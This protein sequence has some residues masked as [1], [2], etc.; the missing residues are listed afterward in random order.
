LTDFECMIFEFYPDSKLDYIGKFAA[1]LGI[2]YSDNFLQIPSP[3]GEGFIKEVH[4]ESD[5]KI[6]IHKYQLKQGLTIRRLV[7]NKPHN[8]LTFRFISRA[9]MNKNYLSNVQVLN[10]HVAIDD[11]ITP[12]EIVYY[13]IVSISKDKLMS[14]TELNAEIREVKS[15]FNSLNKPLLYQEAVTFEMNK[16]LEELSELQENGMLEK[17]YYKM[18]IVELLY[19]FFNRFF[20][21]S[22][23]NATHANKLDIEKIITIEKVILR[24]LSVQPNLPSLAIE[25]GMSGTKM[26]SLFK[27]I[28][29]SSIYNYYQ[30]ARMMEAASLLK[31]NKN[32]S[33]SEVGYQ[34]GFSNLGHF[35]RIFKKI[36][37]VNPK[38]YAK[39]RLF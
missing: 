26:K 30:H 21:R 7:A 19:M 6:L 1:Q 39:A 8:T 22:I 38:E 9:S 12:D 29:G 37:G 13:V 18:R 36:M 33:V 32:L 14:L 31:I 4:L 20:K 11:F 23:Q 10:C 25:A 16:I 15:F 35:S 17:F 24:D 34:L 3:L 28:F 27:E 2:T 5:L